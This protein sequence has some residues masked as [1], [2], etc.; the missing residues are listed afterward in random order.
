[1][2]VAALLGLV[3]LVGMAVGPLMYYIVK[4]KYTLAGPEDEKDQ[5]VWTSYVLYRADEWPGDH[6]AEIAQ[7]YL[8][9]GSP[10]YVKYLSRLVRSETYP[11]FGQPTQP[12][13]PKR[14]ETLLIGRSDQPK[15]TL[16]SA[17]KQLRADE[18]RRQGR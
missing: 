3:G 18:R 14:A 2:L 6:S 12:P 7:R 1:M 8:A 17:V 13:V 9:R 11:I 4:T 5:A 15:P 10:T 16:M